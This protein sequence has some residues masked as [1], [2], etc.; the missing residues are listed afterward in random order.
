M[1]VKEQKVTNIKEILA[2]SSP[3]TLKTLFTAIYEFETNSDPNNLK[4]LIE[5]ALNQGININVQYNDSTLLYSAIIIN[6]YDITKFILEKGANV[7]FPQNFRGDVP[8]HS[9][10]RGSNTTE[11]I[12]IAELLLQNGALIESKNEFDYTPVQ[13]AV[14]NVVCKNKLEITKLFTKYGANLEVVFPI[15]KFPKSSKEYNSDSG[16]NLIELAS[17][18][19]YELK[20]FLK[21]AIACNN[22]NFSIVDKSVTTEDIQKFAEWKISIK[23]ENSKFFSKHLN[24]LCNLKNFLLTKETFKESEFIGKIDDN[25]NPYSS[26]KNLLMFKMVEEPKIYEYKAGILPHDLIDEFKDYELKLKGVVKPE[27]SHSTT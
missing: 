7:N 17:E 12:R 3:I 14:C 9:V 2:S 21:L 24:E 23:P 10:I 15:S 22:K 11:Q 16:K 1:N 8:L 20:A 26:L 25:L 6:S 4:L 19:E 27:E 13:N 5:K 18:N